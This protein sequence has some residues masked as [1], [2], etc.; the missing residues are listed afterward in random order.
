MGIAIFALA[1]LMIP[2]TVQT[3]Y[4]NHNECEN[5]VLTETTPE[6]EKRD[7]NGNGFVCIDETVK[8]NGKTKI[9]IKDDF[10]TGLC[11]PPNC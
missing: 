2:A 3:S 4:A 11:H 1:G 8:N 10:N 5:G 7:K 9:K 6:T